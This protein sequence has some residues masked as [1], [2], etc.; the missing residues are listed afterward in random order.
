[1]LSIQQRVTAFLFPVESDAWLSMLR[2][3]T[4]LQVTFYTISLRADWNELF[5]KTRWGLVNR[6]LT[7]AVLDVQSPF[8]P[9]LGW[10]ISIGGRLGVAETTVLW[11]VWGCLLFAGCCLIFG[12]FSRS[13]AVTAWL[14]HLC[15]VNS[16][17][18]L[19]YGMDNF[20]TIGLFYLLVSPLPDRF[21]LD[22]RVRKL[23]PRNIQ[24]LGFFRRTLQLHL[25]FIYFFG[26]I[27]KVVGGEWWNGTSVWRALT[28]PPFNLIPPSV[29]ISCRYVLPVVG[30]AT[31]VL[32]SGYAIFIWPK[33]TR[34]VWLMCTIGMH[35]TIA[36]TMG[37]YLFSLIM[38]TL[39]AAAFGP[40]LVFPG[41]RAVIRSSTFDKPSIAEFAFKDRHKHSGRSCSM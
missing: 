28:S 37:L 18:L 19:S 17:E 4:G 39:N 40:G 27:M 23:L 41:R 32:E 38:I 22:S 30:I 7:E 29:L 5:T 24:F 13:A 10:L 21:S 20:T 36:L 12:L 8:A 25:C 14:L 1:M 34:A 11:A 6:E 31:C 9:R 2:I 15:T 35:V 33:R 16:E 26:G 3:G